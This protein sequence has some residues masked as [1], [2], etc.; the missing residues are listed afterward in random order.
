LNDSFRE[1]VKEKMRKLRACLLVAAVVVTG[2][3]NAGAVL[4]REDRIAQTQTDPI[5]YE[6][7]MEEIK[8]GEKG[9]SMPKIEYYKRSGFLTTA[10]VKSLEA[11]DLRDVFSQPHELW[12]VFPAGAPGAEEAY[13]EY[14]WLEEENPAAGPDT[15]A[16]SPAPEGKTADHDDYWYVDDENWLEES[17]EGDDWLE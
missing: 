17:A 11:S 7:K 16:A 10:P 13:D 9:P 8:D 1:T 2:F 5:L 6:Q 3:L 12:E 14:W 4:Q 15:S